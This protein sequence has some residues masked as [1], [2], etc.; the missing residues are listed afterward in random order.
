MAYP[1]KRVS[2]KDIA[3]DAGVSV[4]TVSLALRERPGIPPDTRQRVM[5]VARALGYHSSNSKSTLPA[6]IKNVGLVVKAYADDLPQT[7]QFYSYVIAGIET[8]CRQQ[9]INLLLATVMVDDYNLPVEIPSI[10]T[11]GVLDGLLLVGTLIDDPIAHLLSR[12]NAPIILVDAYT[13][14]ADKTYD[15][16]L[17]GN[18]SGAYQAAVYLI[19]HGHRHIGIVGGGVKSFPSL[20]ERHE[21]FEQAVREIKDCHVYTLDCDT[22]YSVTDSIVRQFLHDYPQITAVF[23]V[24]DI[25]AICVMRVAREM[26]KR[27]PQ[28]LSVIGFDDIVMSAHMVPPLTTMQIDKINM[29]RI[30]VQLLLNRVSAPDSSY[31]SSMIVP[32][33]IERQSVLKLD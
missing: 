14:N 28:D 8:A 7:N 32:R 18:H 1:G 17:S 33:L 21:G 11:E 15:A 19:E 30:G 10:L 16:V 26:G 27:I 6:G 23:G 29:G 20:K 24:N 3:R 2:M 5:V 12:L 9:N 25:T 4:S 13:A 31:V 22:K